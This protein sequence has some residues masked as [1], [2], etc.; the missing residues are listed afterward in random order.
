MTSLP[1][2]PRKPDSVRDTTLIRLPGCDALSVLHRVTTQKLDDLAPGHARMTLFCDFRGRLLHRAAVTVTSDGTVW[3]LRD[4]APAPEL[5]AF[6]DRCVFREDVRI[7][8]T[9]GGLV[10]S[11]VEGGFGLALGTVVETDGVPTQVQVADAFGYAVAEGSARA[12]ETPA[13]AE[14]ERQRIRAARPRH[15]HE[16]ADPFNP[17]EVGLGHEVHLSKGCFTGQEVLLRLMTYHSVRRRLAIVGGAGAAPN[18]PSNLRSDREPAG[19][20]TSAAADA[21]GWI[22]L[23]TVKKEMLDRGAPLELENGA[24]VA[25][26][27]PL[28]ETPPLGWSAG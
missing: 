3:L 23:A 21:S 13:D 4:D 10:V 8:P 1:T 19:L 18:A 24:T 12:T 14:A 7:E 25:R 6:V 27:E 2:Q 16:I 28:P 11:G 22:G 5:A 9:A 15:G 26:L 20:L 17:F